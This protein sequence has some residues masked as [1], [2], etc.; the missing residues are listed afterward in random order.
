MIHVLLTTVGEVLDRARNVGGAAAF[1][2]PGDLTAARTRHG[3]HGERTLAGRAAL[4]L[5]LAHVLG[6]AP[7]VAR[8]LAVDRTCERCGSAHG[9]PRASGVSLSSSTS[10]GH[11][12]VAVGPAKVQIGVDVQALP[13][14]IWPGFDAA[15]LHPCE[16]R[17]RDGA[18]VKARIDLWT[19]KEAVLKAA[20]V[21]LQI[22]PSRLRLERED[23]PHPESCCW[24]VGEGSPGELLGLHVRDLPGVVPHAIAASACSP[25]RKVD[26]SAVLPAS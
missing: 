12:L 13:A 22:D 18:D 5:L 3:A 25:V 20:G 23:H 21:G 7:S 14:T 6:D 15:V 4:R 8:T 19:R 24:A 2:S 1:V 9:R 11:V 16:R 10:E 17:L 26:V